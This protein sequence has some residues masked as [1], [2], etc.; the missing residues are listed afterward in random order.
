MNLTT[1]SLRR[2]C[3]FLALLLLWS[4]LVTWHPGSGAAAPLTAFPASQIEG[5]VFDART[6]AAVAGA[7]ISLPGQPALTVVSDERGLFVL[8]GIRVANDYQTVTVQVQAPGYGTWTM[9]NTLLYPGIT[10]L[11][12]VPL[13]TE[14]VTMQAELPR[15]LTDTGMPPA[16]A[17]PSATLPLGLPGLQQVG[18]DTPPETIRVARTGHKLCGDWLAAGRPVLSV[19]ELPLDEYV[20]NVLPNEWLASWPQDSLRAGAMAVKHFAWYKILTRVRHAETGADVLDNTCD[21]YYAPNSRHAS[22]DAAVDATWPY[23]MRQNGQVFAIFYLNLP[24]RCTSS[25]YQPCM[26]QWGTK[27]DAD[28]GRDWQWMLYQYYAPHEIFDSGAGTPEPFVPTPTPEPIT[29]DPAPTPTPEPFAP[30]PVTL[31]DYSYRVVS[32]SPQYDSLHT[33]PGEFVLLLRNEGIATWYRTATTAGNTT[34]HVVHLATGRPTAAPANPYDLPDHD[35]P[36]YTSKGIGWWDGTPD[37][38]RIVMQEEAVPPGAMATFRFSVGVPAEPGLFDMAFT[39][40]VEHVGWME[41]QEGTRIR[42]R[43]N[44]YH[45]ETRQQTPTWSATLEPGELRVFSVTF[46]NT[47][48]APWERDRTRLGIAAQS[49]GWPGMS[50]Q[51]SPF[52]HSSWLQQEQPARLHEQRV[53]PGNSGT[54]TFVVEA[55]A[56]PGV[57]LLRVRPLVLDDWWMSLPSAAT[58]TINVVEAAPDTS[59]LAIVPAYVEAQ[60]EQTVSV[61]VVADTAGASVDTIAAHLVFDPA[62]LELIEVT[63]PTTTTHDITYAAGTVAVVATAPYWPHLNGRLTLATLHFRVRATDV[64]ASIAFVRDSG[65]MSDLRYEGISLHPAAYR[66]GLV[67]A[68]NQS[69]AYLPLVVR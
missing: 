57:Y 24:E 53:V 28:A 37:H 8:E 25:L 34:G 68:R 35:S 64:P 62:A 59:R 43:S 55:P 2:W 33:D 13:G 11:L 66:G 23:V 20:K 18:H 40:V 4:G 7:T 54:F 32:R 46:A 39:P 51:S 45:A 27:Y 41:H 47:G 30:D 16:E 9:H 69:R 38:N 56:V 48:H 12:D 6:G 5:R 58:W 49:G 60:P 42:V 65:R 22:T 63:Q 17:V 26:P 19:E 15:A 31:A 21:Q 10:R 14:P 61:D 50:G 36:F 29:P 44:P 67:L 3:M 1:N 52:A